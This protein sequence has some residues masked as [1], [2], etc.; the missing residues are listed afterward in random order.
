MKIEIQRSASAGP[1]AGPRDHLLP[2][3]Q[4]LP[5]LPSTTGSACS[6]EPSSTI[7]GT[8][9]ARA[10]V[11]SS[12]IVSNEP[13][14]SRFRHGVTR[15]DSATLPRGDHLFLYSPYWKDKRISGGEVVYSPEYALGS[16]VPPVPPMPSSAELSSMSLGSG[17]MRRRSTSSIGDILTPQSEDIPSTP[18]TPNLRHKRTISLTR[19]PKEQ[20]AMKR[21]SRISEASSPAPSPTTPGVTGIY[22][23]TSKTNR[24]SQ[25]HSTSG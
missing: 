5:G 14:N 20:I 4:A 22:D 7:S 24:L 25:A 10:L 23:D 15:Q 18:G 2:D 6:E 9:L 13:R 11:A 21:F 1:S 3:A 12:F 8:S 17:R 19:L 16:P